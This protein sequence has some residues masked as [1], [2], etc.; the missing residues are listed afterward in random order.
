[1]RAVLVVVAD[2]FREQ[3]FQMTFIHRDNMVQQILSA[4][5]DPTLRC[6]VLP[7]TL[8]GGPYRVHPQGSNGCRDFPPVLGISIED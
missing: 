8:E 3:P 5:L 2:V 7:G 1:M 6:T 4:A